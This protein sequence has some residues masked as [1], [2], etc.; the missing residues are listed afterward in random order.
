MKAE[1]L[2]KLRHLER[3]DGTIRVCEKDAQ[4]I[5]LHNQTVKV[6]PSGD[7]VFLQLIPI[8]IGVYAVKR[9]PRDFDSEFGTL[10]LSPK[11]KWITTEKTLKLNQV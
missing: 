11:S 4:Q 9:L 8:G 10:L 5:L 2:E 3:Y 7:I 1:T 6:Y